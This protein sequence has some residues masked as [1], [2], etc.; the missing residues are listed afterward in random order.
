MID[1]ANARAGFKRLARNDLFGEREMTKPL[2][3]IE[4]LDELVSYWASKTPDACVCVSGDVRLSY[5]ELKAEIDTLAKALLANGIR[6]GDRVATLTT[7]SPEFLTAFL[8]TVSIGGIWLGLN[9]RHQIEELKYVVSDSAPRVLLTRTRIDGRDYVGEIQALKDAVPSLALIV[10]LGDGPAV[11]GAVD[12]ASFLASASRTSDSELETARQCVAGPDPCLIVYTSGST[13][14]PKGALV[15]HRAIAR[16][17]VRLVA[18]WPISPFILLHYFPINHVSGTCDAA[19]PALAAGGTMVFME[20]FDAENSLELMERERVTFWASVPSTFQMQL[21]LPDFASYDLS[22][23]QLIMWG[24][25]AASEPLIR[26]LLEF[27]APAATHY[28]MTETMFTTLTGPTRDIDVLANTVGFGF[29]E[30][31]I[32]LVR[33]NGQD[34]EEG[35]PGEIWVRSEYNLI[36]Y[37]NRPDA[38]ADAITPDGFFKTGDVAVRRPDGN[39]RISGRLKEMYK[40]GGYNV[41]PREIETVLEDFPAVATVAVVSTPDPLWQEVGVAFVVPNGPVKIE[42]LGSHC[43]AHLANYKIPKHFFIESAL[44]LLPNGKIDKVGLTK[45]AAERLSVS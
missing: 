2:Q 9:S 39:Y 22:S 10:T 1:G 23:V 40:S 34:A 43:R 37:L 31:E 15:P 16:F 20:H 8:A 33:D 13:G 11:S 21:A 17:A 44:P 18:I 38:T 32:R 35:E 25:A 6:K 30:V 19:A 42:E 4:R 29:P 41:Y 28:G 7:P 45:A 24:G 26:R 14:R 12:L 27:G 5:A 36:G 3:N